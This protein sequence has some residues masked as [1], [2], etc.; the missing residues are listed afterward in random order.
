MVSFNVSS[1][2]PYFP[3]L[4]EQKVLRVLNQLHAPL[5]L[6]IT[7]CISEAIKGNQKT[8]EVNKKTMRNSR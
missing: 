6:F 7:F 4:K 1:F 8:T 5:M 2:L 3:E